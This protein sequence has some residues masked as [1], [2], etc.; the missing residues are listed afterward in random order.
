MAA[1]ILGAGTVRADTTIRLGMLSPEIPPFCLNTGG[2]HDPTLSPYSPQVPGVSFTKVQI[3]VSQAPVAVSGGDLDMAECA[4]AS[5]IIQA[6]MKGAKNVV[7]VYVGSAKPSYVLIARKGINSLTE[8]KGKSIASPGP[9]S[10]ATEASMTIMSRGGHFTVGTD[11]KLVSTG[12][13]GARAA[14]LSVGKIDAVP[15]FPP[16]S[17]KLIDEGFRQ[18]AQ[19][20]DWA[21]EYV[22][23]SLL[24]NRQ[25][26]ARNS[27]TLVAILKTF[28]QTGNWLKDPKN[29]DA[30]IQAFA[31]KV[32]EGASPMGPDHAKRFYAD[33]VEG[34]RVAFEGY[35]PPSAFQSNEEIMAERSGSK[36]QYPPLHEVVDYS[37]LNRALKELGMAPV[38]LAP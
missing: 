25:W 34:K 9:Q 35:A 29:K 32:K 17:Y 20:S 18:V 31:T 33:V 13:G 8:M 22:A 15:S 38:P 23:G 1:G 16:F 30:V 11:Y 7:L 12:T 19:Q 10:T 28:I 4:G 24:V 3:S 6:W 37:Y 21:P 36:E 26:A 5:S 27:D 14:A 2:L